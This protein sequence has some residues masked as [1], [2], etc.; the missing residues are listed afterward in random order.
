MSMA[1]EQQPLAPEPRSGRCRHHQC[2]RRRVRA[3]L[4]PDHWSALMG[5]RP[6]PWPADLEPM[7]REQRAYAARFGTL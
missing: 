1:A 2:P 4:C 5:D 7:S 3:G 6:A